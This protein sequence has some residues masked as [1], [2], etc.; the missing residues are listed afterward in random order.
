MKI[1]RSNEYQILQR[2]MINDL[3]SGRLVPAKSSERSAYLEDYVHDPRRCLTIVA[4]PPDDMTERIERE[5]INPLRSI[6][7]DFYFYPK[8]SL[9]TTIQGIQPVF[10]PPLFSKADKAKVHELLNLIV[11]GLPAVSLYFQGLI[12]FP[13]GS[14]TSISLA[15]YS[16]ERLRKVICALNKGLHDA[17]IGY[18]D[19]YHYSK[20]LFFG[21]IAVCRFTH[22]PQESFLRKIEEL[23]AVDLGE[24]FIDRLYLVTCNLVC[25]T[26]SREV[27]GSY[28]LKI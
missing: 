25:D 18:N 20:E 7:P 24:F 2:K 26:K 17:D 19:K 9:H 4:F 3:K 1:E 27:I 16:D 8:I 10:D 23:D 11:P 12:A 21:S 22:R 5:I 6:E 14:P 28:K 13:S 15:G